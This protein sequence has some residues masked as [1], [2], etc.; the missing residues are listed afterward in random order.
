MIGFLKIP[1]HG[2]LWFAFVVQCCTTTSTS[3]QVLL[4]A[5]SS[6]SFATTSSSRRFPP[7]PDYPAPAPPAEN[8]VVEQPSSS[9]SS[10]L[11]HD[12][13]VGSEL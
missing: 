4:G 9:L 7:V 13:P 3:L 11:P 10:V 2:L 6:R 5:S 8:V 1:P 12:L